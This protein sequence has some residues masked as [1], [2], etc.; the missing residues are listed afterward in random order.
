[1]CCTGSS[2]ALCLTAANDC[3]PHCLPAGCLPLLRQGCALGSTR[4]PRA[5]AFA[6]RLMLLEA[7]AAY[8]NPSFLGDSRN[9]QVTFWS[10][11]HCPGAGAQAKCGKPTPKCLQMLFSSRHRSP[12]LPPFSTLPPPPRCYRG[13][14]SAA[15]MLCFVFQ[16]PF[17]SHLYSN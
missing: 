13:S 4:E 3:D 9:A 17:K 16:Q 11:A 1:M 2:C 10:R 6:Q 8:T 14:D 15:S 5:P 12:F 7:G